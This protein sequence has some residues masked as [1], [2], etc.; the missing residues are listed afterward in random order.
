MSRKR[1]QDDME[2]A[3]I[4]LHAGGDKVEIASIVTKRL[5]SDDVEDVEEAMSSLFNLL[6][7]IHNN[8][9]D[10]NRKTAVRRGALL[11]L[12]QALYRHGDSATIRAGALAP[13]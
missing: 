2:T 10:E 5:S 7:S 3:P 11:A 4:V 12:V 9:A 1:R 8:N 13:L 6:H